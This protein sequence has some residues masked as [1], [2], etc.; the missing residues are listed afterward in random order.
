MKIKSIQKTTLIDFPNLIAA[1]FFCQGC[2]FNCGFCYN[3]ALIELADPPY[4]AKEEIFSFLEQRK[5]LLEGVVLTGGEP[6]LQ[7]D[8]VPFIKEIKKYP[9]K[10]KLDTNGYL[11]QVIKELIEKK[12]VDYIAMDI[13]A[14]LYKYRDVV[15]SEINIERIKES[16]SLIMKSR[17]EYEFR[18]T[19]WHDFFTLEDLFEI[20]ELIKGASNYSLQNFYAHNNHKSKI[21]KPFNKLELAPFLNGKLLVKKVTLKGDW[22]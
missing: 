5:H 22:F 4:L 2:N 12:L 9:I 14:P 6:T 15:N 19:I 21:F 18:T 11:P 1:S 20:A 13:K 8:I 10:V 7:S 3:Q 17:V 16:I